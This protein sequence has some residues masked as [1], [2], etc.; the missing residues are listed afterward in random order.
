MPV[1]EKISWLNREKKYFKFIYVLIA[2]F[3]LLILLNSLI[4]F[5]SHDEFE[6]IHS[7]WYIQQGYTPYVDFFQGHH[8]LLWFMIVPFLALLGH[9]IP[10]VII[11]RLFMLF[12]SAGIVVLVYKTAKIVLR[13]KEAALLAVVFLLSMVMFVEK[14]IEIRPDVPQVFFALLSL[15]FLLHF[16]SRQKAKYI[17]SAGI[18]AAV[19][20]LFLQ[21]SIFLM[22]AMGVI[23]IFKLIKKEISWRPVL[24]FG[25]CFSL[26][27]LVFA[28]Y[29][30]LTRSFPD[31]ILTNWLFHM[32]H[33]KSL[34][35]TRFLLQSFMQ[36]FIFWII[37]ITGGLLILF[38]GEKNRELRMIAGLALF[39][40][41]S[42]FV[43][44]HPYR[45]NFL[46]PISLLSIVVGYFLKFLFF[47]CKSPAGL[48]IKILV[49]FILVPFI[50]LCTMMFNSNH[51]QFERI[52][53]VLANTNRT[54]P[55][56][57]G[58]TRFNLY[59]PDL[60]YFWYAIINGGLATYNK[61]TDNRFADY[62]AV[63]LILSK[64]PKLISSFGIDIKKSGLSKYYKKT[65]YKNLYR[66]KNTLD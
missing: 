52:R 39:L 37:S 3:S 34:L 20:F 47:K 32:K 50:F 33:I 26:P 56:Y 19:S 63:K 18:F 17:C 4:R 41:F 23:L 45:Q 29:L 2:V 61:I 60:H 5:F 36:N 42:V 65:P 21:K 48:K 9:T 64:Q 22:A 54:D 58:D 1:K 59:R 43:M 12:F 13:S 14:G 49:L 11:I 35:P 31:Y 27:L 15:Y 24:L 7:A 16:F 28:G 44:K 66:R 30:L 8:P 10:A 6:H 62:D 46:L 57:D 40:F 55:V 25:C 38:R 51:S 53:F